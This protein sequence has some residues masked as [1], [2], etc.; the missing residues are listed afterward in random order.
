MSSNA[1]ANTKVSTS[2]L[3]KRKYETAM[4]YENEEPE[5]QEQNLDKKYEKIPHFTKYHFQTPEGRMQV[6]EWFNGYNEYLS[7]KYSISRLDL[8]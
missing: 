8:S 7:S 1:N 3:G 5:I 2:I 6:N 4:G